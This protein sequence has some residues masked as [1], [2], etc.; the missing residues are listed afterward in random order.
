MCMMSGWVMRNFRIRE[1]AEGRALYVE[2]FVQ[3]LT[4]CELQS[5]EDKLGR[6][7]RRRRRRDAASKLICGAHIQMG[8]TRN[9]DKY[10]AEQTLS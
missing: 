1:K 7:N 8:D 6:H 3:T 2:R 9:S 5:C 10:E 4:D